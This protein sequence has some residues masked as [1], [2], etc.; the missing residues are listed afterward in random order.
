M[1]PA[2]HDLGTGSISIRAGSAFGECVAAGYALGGALA[3][4]AVLVAGTVENGVDGWAGV[5]LYGCIA[6]G[7]GGVIGLVVGLVV[8][9]LLFVLVRFGERR[10]GAAAVARAMPIVALAITL[11]VAFL[12]GSVAGE[13]WFF[14]V[15]SVD[16]VLTVAAALVIAR[17]YLR[18]CEVGHLH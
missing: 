15:V 14:S 6:A 17:H 10:V 5:V 4:V 3:F 18:R 11:P 8:G 9:V 13:L 16:A 2:P 1:T 7:F 12:I